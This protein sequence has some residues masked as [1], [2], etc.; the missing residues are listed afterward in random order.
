MTLYE[1]RNGSNRGGYGGILGWLSIKHPYE[2]LC[3][4]FGRL[5]IDRWPGHIQEYPAGQSYLV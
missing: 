1:S 5:K 4:I 2:I 3:R